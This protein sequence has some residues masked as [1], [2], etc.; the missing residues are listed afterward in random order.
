MTL[1]TEIRRKR[2]TAFFLINCWVFFSLSGRADIYNY[3]VSFNICQEV[4][5][6]PHER[7]DRLKYDIAIFLNMMK[8]LDHSNS[9]K[10]YWWPKYHADLLRME[11]QKSFMG[12][13]FRYTNIGMQKEMRCT[14]FCG[15][16]TFCSRRNRHRWDRG[17]L[18]FWFVK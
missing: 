16:P 13:E 7:L 2:L 4:N 15:C 12:S 18:V 5:F 1:K 3:M 11:S 6:F 17:Y 14:S 8:A 10:K 9:P